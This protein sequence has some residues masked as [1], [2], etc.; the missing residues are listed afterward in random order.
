M[1]LLIPNFIGW[2]KLIIKILIYKYCPRDNTPEEG[3]RSEKLYK[4]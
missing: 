4:L 3:F 2:E 1:K